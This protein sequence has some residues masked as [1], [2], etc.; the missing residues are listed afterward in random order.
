MVLFLGSTGTIWRLLFVELL[1]DYF[2][3]FRCIEKKTDEKRRLK[4]L[5]SE[6][7]S[8]A[9]SY[10]VFCMLNFE[11][12]FFSKV[13]Q[14]RKKLKSIHSVAKHQKIEGGPFGEFFSRS[15]EVKKTEMRDPLVSPGIL[16]YAGKRGKTFLVHFAR[17]NDSIWDHQ[18]S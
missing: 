3:H 4:R 9:F 1:V 14:C 17:P 6:K 8:H 13:S 5:A 18:I 11:T 2:G 15:H 12:H 16:C 7:P 10:L